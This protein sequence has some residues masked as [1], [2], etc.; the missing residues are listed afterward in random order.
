MFLLILRH[1]W[2]NHWNKHMTTGRI[3]QVSSLANTRNDLLQST[4]KYSVERRTSL[5]EGRSP[6]RQPMFNKS[7]PHRNND[8]VSHCQ[9]HAELPLHRVGSIGKHKMHVTRRKRFV[10]QDR[11]NHKR[12]KP[13]GWENARTKRKLQTLRKWDTHEATKQARVPEGQCKRADN[14]SKQIMNFTLATP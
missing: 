5:E 13:Q 10:H 11:N 7:S 3:N 14:K 12:R 6:P 1:A 4:V 9:W 8:Q 2:L